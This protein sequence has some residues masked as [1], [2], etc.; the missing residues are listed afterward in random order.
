M[1]RPPQSR[2]PLC[3]PTISTCK[4]K[5]D[6]YRVQNKDDLRSKL[7]QKGDVVVA[8]CAN[9]EGNRQREQK[10]SCRLAY[11]Q[12]LALEMEMVGEVHPPPSPAGDLFK[13]YMT[14]SLFII[15]CHFLHAHR[16]NKH[17]KV[18]QLQNA[19]HAATTTTFLSH[20]GAGPREIV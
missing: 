5:D 1:G 4:K 18:C 17:R 16:R 13:C 11:Q 6:V 8:C 3:G 14:T 19:H 7:D 15:L 2:N 12:K 9:R 20:P 10:K